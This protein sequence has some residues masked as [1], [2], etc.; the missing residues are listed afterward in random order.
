MLQWCKSSGL[1]LDFPW[2]NSRKGPGRS[3]LSVLWDQYSANSIWDIILDSWWLGDHI[4]GESGGKKQRANFVMKTLTTMLVSL[5]RCDPSLE[6]GLNQQ[7]CIFASGKL[8]ISSSIL[9]CLLCPIFH[10]TACVSPFLFAPLV[11][12]LQPD[13]HEAEA[14]EGTDFRCAESTAEWNERTRLWRLQ[15]QLEGVSWLAWGMPTYP[16]LLVIQVI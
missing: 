6:M 12:E 16:F 3:Q 15:E 7:C 4:K 2:T 9:H 8:K 11:T 5:W 10:C 1:H 13:A 14:E